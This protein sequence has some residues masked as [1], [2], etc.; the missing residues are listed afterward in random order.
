MI[1]GWINMN[2]LKQNMRWLS[3]ILLL[4]FTFTVLSIAI[5]HFIFTYYFKPDID[6]FKQKMIYSDQVISTKPFRMSM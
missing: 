6:A 3:L 1:T 4:T 5:G 2:N